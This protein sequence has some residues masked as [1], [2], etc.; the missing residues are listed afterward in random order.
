MLPQSAHSAPNYATTALSLNPTAFWQL[1]ETSD[2]SLGGAVAHDSSG[3]GHDGIYGITSENGFNNVVSPQPPQFPG[4][5]NGQGA[6]QTALSDANSPV[7]IPA[8][9]LNTNAVTIMMWI[10]PSANETASTGLLS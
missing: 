3:N 6:L 4:F 5:T 7:L 9:N 8:L 2:P 10:N 1:T